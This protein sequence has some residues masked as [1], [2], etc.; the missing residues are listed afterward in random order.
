M[1]SSKQTFLFCSQTESKFFKK[2]LKFLTKADIPWS[3]RCKLLLLKF[4]L[5]LMLLWQIKCIFSSVHL[6]FKSIFTASTFSLQESPQTTIPET[7]TSLFTDFKCLEK[8]IIFQIS[9]L[10]SCLLINHLYLHVK[11]K[12]LAGDFFASVSCNHTYR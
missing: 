1:T 4:R 12:Y 8:V 5:T 9:L 7:T 11:C 10:V 6:F 2:F 3:F